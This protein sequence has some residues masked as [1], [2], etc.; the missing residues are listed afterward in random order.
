MDPSK[1][2]QR[3]IP[4]KGTSGL[5][6]SAARSGWSG[7]PAPRKAL[8]SFCTALGSRWRVA[9]T[10][11]LQW[12]VLSTLGNFDTPHVYA[13]NIEARME[14]APWRGLLPRWARAACVRV[15]LRLGI[16]NDSL[17]T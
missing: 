15:V 7:A 5:S 13:A 2:R 4:P 10:Q 11:P 16:R 1:N 17:G 3:S 12:T 8:N 6:M 9:N 14:D